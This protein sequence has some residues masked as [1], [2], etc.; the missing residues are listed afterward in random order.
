MPIPTFHFDESALGL[1]RQPVP[2]RFACFAANW[3]IGMVATALTPQEDF[4]GQ[5][6]K[7]YEFNPENGYVGEVAPSFYTQFRHLDFPTPETLALI[8]ANHFVWSDDLIH[9]F[10]DFVRL[11][12]SDED[13][14]A[15]AAGVRWNPA[16]GDC[17]E[18]VAHSTDLSQLQPSHVDVVPSG[19][20]IYCVDGIWTL[21]FMGE[22]VRIKS[23]KGIRYINY[24]LTHPRKEISAVDFYRLINPSPATPS[25]FSSLH[26]AV[27]AGKSDDETS[28]FDGDH[29]GSYTPVVDDKAKRDAHE[30]LEELEEK[31]NRL[32]QVGDEEGAEK[33][34][35]E[36]DKILAWLNAAINKSGQSRSFNQDVERIQ[37]RKYHDA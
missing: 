22:T 26:E 2:V 21:E 27:D 20:R 32:I 14:Q 1:P 17:Y 6:L 8:P 28:G 19:N 15:A 25:S 12:W 13:A 9:A 16:L 37:V 23:S 35:D 29:G 7:V 5:L 10:S 11:A 31:K 36:Q 24:L 34:E 33:I 3:S 30:K 18:V 4:Y